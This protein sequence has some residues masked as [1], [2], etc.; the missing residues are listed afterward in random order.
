MTDVSQNSRE[1]G[2]DFFVNCDAVC[3]E[4][5][6][7]HKQSKGESALREMQNMILRDVEFL[8]NMPLQTLNDRLKRYPF[9]DPSPFDELLTEMMAAIL[10][11]VQ[12][13]CEPDWIAEVLHA[14]GDF[15]TKHQVKGRAASVADDHGGQAD[16]QRETDGDELESRREDLDELE[17]LGKFI[18]PMPLKLRDLQFMIRP[19]MEVRSHHYILGLDA[20]VAELV[21]DLLRLYYTIKAWDELLVRYIKK[22]AEDSLEENAGPGTMTICELCACMEMDVFEAAHRLHHIDK[23]KYT[24]TKGEIEVI[25]QKLPIFQDKVLM[26]GPPVATFSRSETL[27]H[28]INGGSPGPQTPES[29][30]GRTKTPLDQVRTQALAWWRNEKFGPGIATGIFASSLL[31]YL[32]DRGLHPDPHVAEQL[33]QVME[34]LFSHHL[35]CRAFMNKLLPMLGGYVD[36]LGQEIPLGHGLP[37]QTDVGR[38]AESMLHFLRQWVDVTRKMANVDSNGQTI[39]R[40]AAQN[41]KQQR[42]SVCSSSLANANVKRGSLFNMDAFVQELTGEK[43][44]VNAVVNLLEGATLIPD[45]VLNVPVEDERYRV[46]GDRQRVWEHSTGQHTDIHETLD[47]HHRDLGPYLFIDLSCQDSPENVGVVGSAVINPLMAAAAKKGYSMEDDSDEEE[48]GMIATQ[49]IVKPLAFQGH[50]GSTNLSDA[51]GLRLAEWPRDLVGS[52]AE[53]SSTFVSYFTDSGRIVSRGCLQGLPTLPWS[54][55]SDQRN[56]IILDIPG[57]G[58]APFH[59]IFSQSR[60]QPLRPCIVAL[61]GP[62][63]PSYIVCPKYQPIHLQNGDRLVCHQ[64]NFEIRIVTT[65]L[66]QTACQVLTDEGDVFDVPTD[67]CHVGA[68]NRSRQ[69]PNQPIFPATKFALKHRLKDMSAVH[70]AITYHAPSNRWMLLDHSPEPLGTLLL[71]KTGTSYPLSHGLRVK[72][73]PL[74]FETVINV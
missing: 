26:K 25:C 37:L 39:I 13:V 31:A 40:S 15:L 43:H 47:A 45:H 12:W 30:S 64:W 36:S 17:E 32:M 16:E 4:L 44:D 61:G 33:P 2:L 29:P 14:I 70:M 27:N 46:D 8:H 58:I 42:L 41:G 6:E 72:L 74:I 71:L 63:V 57:P 60:A 65:G 10:E 9:V 20:V 34:A 66:H 24:I 23:Q 11:W 52:G 53:S 69:V 49:S 18:Y 1:R 62:L 54:F 48:N 35:S 51:F 50:A 73:G 67:G 55:G 19:F 56:S 22:L 3:R 7:H 28:L 68:G 59:C 5:R 21:K 38:C